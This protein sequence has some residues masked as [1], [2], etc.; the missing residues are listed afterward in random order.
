MNNIKMQSTRI[1]A[2]FV[3]PAETSANAEKRVLTLVKNQW[4]DGVIDLFYF[5]KKKKH[6]NKNSPVAFRS[7]GGALKP[8][9]HFSLSVW[10]G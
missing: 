7:G 2:R 4:R 8:I 1:S 10:S 9:W 5:H 3:P 6:N